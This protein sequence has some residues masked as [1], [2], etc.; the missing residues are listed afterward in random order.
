MVGIVHPAAAK[1][2]QRWEGTFGWTW[3]TETRRALRS[4]SEGADPTRSLEE[5]LD[6]EVMEPIEIVNIE[7]EIA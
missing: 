4:S 6:G 1:G 5:H 3:T 7:N 2:V